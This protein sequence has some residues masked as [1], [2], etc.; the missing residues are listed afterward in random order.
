MERALRAFGRMHE[1]RW[2]DRSR[3]WRP[4]ALAMLR[5]AGERMRGSGR[6]RL[7]ALEADGGVAATLFVFA[8]GGEAMAWNGAW[9]PDWAPV[10]PMMALFYRAIEDCFEM[11]DRRLDFGEG[12]QHYKLRL[13]DQQDPV[14]W[15]TILP[16]GR[17]Y[18]LMRL[19]TAP[20]RLRGR[21][22]MAARRLPPGAQARL[23][24]LRARGAAGPVSDEGGGAAP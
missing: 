16:R 3:L 11:G 17:D 21:A 10:R 5:E 15:A 1:L 4:D 18:P 9:Q 12:E 6:L 22:R 20:R 23:R 24:R 13:A 7:Y 14:A 2:G 8:A 19:A